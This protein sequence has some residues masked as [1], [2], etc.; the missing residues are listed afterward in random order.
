MGL[1]L[2]VFVE[3]VDEVAVPEEAVLGAEHPVGLV[4]KIKVACFEAAE[5]GSVVG[6]HALG[7]DDAEVKLAMDDADGGVPTET[8]KPL[9]TLKKNLKQKA[10]NS[11]NLIMIEAIHVLYSMFYHHPK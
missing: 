2:E 9:M 1:F 5:L 10:L 3:P 8:Q 4:G 6:S 11:N 7:G